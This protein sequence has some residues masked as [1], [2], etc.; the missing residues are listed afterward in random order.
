[1][2]NFLKKPI[3]R[4][5][6]NFLV[7]LMVFQGAPYW[8]IARNYEF[9]L[10]GRIFKLATAEAAPLGQN[11]VLK[12]VEYRWGGYSYDN[13]PI[14]EGWMHVRI[15]NPCPEDVF[16]VKATIS[17]W[18]E[19]CEIVD[20][21]VTVGNIPE[22]AS[23]WS[24][25]TF[26]IKVDMANP[27]DPREG[28][29]WTIEYDDTSGVHHIIKNVPEFPIT[30]DVVPTVSLTI[31]PAS[32][33]VDEVVNIRVTAQ[34]NVGLCSLILTVN[35]EEVPYD[36]EGNAT[37]LPTEEGEYTV[38]A[39]ATDADGNIAEDTETFV[40]GVVN[41]PPVAH[42]GPDQTVF[43]GDTV[44]LDGSLSND[45]DGDTLTFSWSFTSLP[46]GS[47][48]TLSDSTIVNPTFMADIAGAYV[49]Q[50]IVNDG[51]LN[52]D[53]DTVVINAYEL[54][55]ANRNPEITSTPPTTADIGEL[56][57]YD[58][59]AT[60]PDGDTLTFSLTKAP[61]G[62][63]INA[64]TGLISWT[65]TEG[66][67]YEVEVQV[68]DGKGGTDTQPFT[69]LVS[70]TANRPPQITSSPVTSATASISYQYDVEATDQ[71]GYPLTFSLTQAPTGMT[72]D[73]GTGL[74]EWTPDNAQIG[75]HDVTVRVEDALGAYDTQSFTITVSAVGDITAPQVNVTV[76]PLEVNPDE[77]VTITV[78]A[79]DDVGVVSIELSV[80]GTPL[81]LDIN[82]QATF[83]SSTPGLFTA[84]A[85]ARD[86]KGN[87]GTDSQDFRVL[88]PGDT[89]AP[90]VSI[91]SPATDSEL[92]SPTD[93]LGT[94]SDDNLVQ[95]TLEYS[96]KDKNTFVTF[97]TGTTSVVNGVLGTL[98]TTTLLNDL[99]DIRLTAEDANGQTSSTNV[100]YRIT[101]DLKVGNF[102]ITLQDLSIPV[103]G[104][105]IT[106]NRTYDSRDKASHDF[107][108]GW[109]IDIQTTKVKENRILGSGWAQLSTGGWLP[110][111]YLQPDGEHYVSITLPDG[112]VEE[113]NFT[114]TPSSQQLV[115]L[116]STTAAF[117]ARP[118][119]FST[120]VPLG[121][122]DLW[123]MGGVGA[124][125]LLDWDTL[126][127]YDP[128]EYQLTTVDG[129]VYIINQ[130]AGIKT[131]TDPNGNTLTFTAN[132]ITHSSGKGV[133]FT[134]DGEGRIT[135]ITDPSGNTITYKYDARG[136]LVSVTDQEG[137]K[138][139]YTYNST[140][141]LLDIKDPRGIRPARNIY[142]DEGRLI[143][144]IDAYGNRI[145][146]EHRVD[147]RQE[148][149][150]DRKGN[151]TVY[152]YD[153]DGNVLS[154]TDP[155]G[156]TT[157]YTYDAR[158]NKLTET[159]PLGNTTKYT[160]DARDN[161]LTQ[162]D[163]LG[164][165]TTY[166]YNARNQVLTTTDPNGN[167]TT[168]TYDANGNLL[169]TTD[170]LGNITTNTYD[171]SG[172][173]LSTTDCLGNVTTYEY[174]AYGNLIKQTDALGNVTTYTY[175][176]NG[177]Q[178]TQTT[179]R[180]TDAGPV[181]MTIT[182]EYDG[183]NRLIKTTDPDGNVTIT[184]YNA[185]GKK[186]ATVDKNGNRTTYEYD[187]MGN[188]IKTTYPDGTTE[189][190]TYDA[191]GNKLTSTDRAGRTTQYE[192]DP[193]NRL[194]QT[195]FP[196]GR[197]TSTE[198]DAA[199]RVIATIDENGNRTS[200][201]YDAAGR[202]TK[203]IDALGNVTTYTYDANG[204]QTSVTDANGNTTRYEYDA[205]NRRIKTIFSDGTFT[206]VGY[207][208]LGRKIS[209]TDQAG[210]TTQ[211]E[212][213]ALGRLTKVIDA[214]G[215]K[216]T[217][218]Y[219]EVGNK[220]SQTDPNG[221]TT[222]WAYDNLGRIVK[223]TL[224]LGMSETFTY[225][226]NGNILTK[227]DFNGNTITYTYDVNNRLT[228]KS[229]P[230]GSQV[231]FTY[232]ATGQRETVTD[233][234]GVTLYSYDLRDRIIEVINPDGTAITYTYD[235][236][237]NR[238][239]VTVPSGTT[240]YTYDKL[241]RLQTVTDPDGGVTTYTYDS[242]GNRASVTYP[243]GTV[244]EYTYDTLN[245]LTYLENRK[246]TGEII[247]SYTYTLGPAGNR[248]RVVED[249]GRAVNY[250]YDNLYRLTEEDITDPVLGDETISY[251]YDAF[252][253]RLTKTD[254]TG[255]TNY[256]YDENDRLLTEEAPTY[257][258]TYTYDDN[259]NT[260]S[261]SDG[262]TVTN[263][264]YD[265]ENRLIATQ[266]GASQ[267][268]Y[269]YDADGIRVRS[270]AN[271]TVT[272][273][274]VDKNRDYAQVLEE[275]DDIGSLIVSYIHGDDLISQNRG[276]SVSYYHYDGQMSTRKL[277][278]AV[279][280][281]TDT[282]VYDAFG[283]LLNRTGTT[284]NNYLYTGEQYDP[285]IGFY[286][287]RARYYAASIGRFLN[288]DPLEGNIYDPRALHKYLYATNNPI[289]LSDPSGQQ[290]SLVSVT[291][292]CAIIGALTAA[293][294]YTYYHPPGSERFTW[295]GFIIWT[296]SGAA[297]GAVVGYLGWYAWLYWGPAVTTTI[298][299]TTYRIGRHLVNRWPHINVL[300]S[301]FIKHGHQIANI[302]RETNYTIQRYAADAAFVKDYYVYKTYNVARGA[303]YYIKYLGVS[304]SGKSYFAFVVE[305]GGKIVSFRP[306]WVK[307]AAKF[308]PELF[309]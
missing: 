211:F 260:I 90:T 209:E 307:D 133:T 116:S 91:T 234:R 33:N 145:D 121:S 295:K 197:S 101:E 77:A 158:G 7:F 222:R 196:D 54:A 22:G 208:C 120:L 48:A 308:F 206:T 261:K 79:T 236:R 13:W 250:T 159:D 277:T 186:S 2:N 229:Y 228:R 188:L 293:A 193:L 149:V 14:F 85:T 294:L 302:L 132:G 136:D 62:M 47:T 127:P 4:L 216:T 289:N 255:V 6:V 283:I 129:T 104:I 263:Y 275:R 32:V 67:N 128:N 240:T 58:V 107:G 41:H 192:Y 207:D 169:T 83:S 61:N 298:G 131:V 81:S 256:T 123:I 177:N 276:G 49:V 18:P 105:P 29:V 53:P 171:A 292:T 281:I 166:T 99:Y 303:W 72:I 181:T 139:T 42:A 11:T 232:T 242:V 52:S 164:N 152:E 10:H 280:M 305:K 291:I 162:T 50:L 124:V 64:S 146:Y 28:V 36:T 35:G 200:Y 111:Y 25:D 39:V 246:S 46:E 235:P 244:T 170:P 220:I 249:S 71:D 110:T 258:N 306:L 19:N 270:T 202:R 265:Y 94:A 135:Q 73:I 154:Q 245:R 17:D 203:V 86:A 24:Q 9:V 266:T 238:T 194:I 226:A 172:N 248:I 251:T 267:T 134:R 219:D 157:T 187:L 237:G 78:D 97:A 80:N 165:T 66:G 84:T 182:N 201:E 12:C 31:E 102:T 212:Y 137:N 82:N 114:P 45:P 57:T 117:T 70:A 8:E 93:I 113:F 125:E 96:P 205:L 155:L 38:L 103:A 221:H 224:P 40:A 286:Y 173:L 254:S 138:T 278:D 65:P 189:T 43:V 215:N 282:Y 252:G 75:Q 151:I 247:S 204:N 285:N 287:L 30:D 142:D 279:E 88:A 122:T 144:H 274:L 141:G 218:T 184:E 304:Q 253:N 163:P 297:A 161:L 296:I 100:V 176:A 118:G 143:A 76:D 230:D 269:D 87:A 1:M 179:T 272:N 15:E 257:S 268:A 264:T 95:Y 288:I 106:I 290:F 20:G 284:V 233:T 147:A 59:E 243:N 148:V 239:S 227:T 191:N 214:L 89:T 69:I 51:S 34:D 168:N 198:Y 309:R 5:L 178:L 190:A 259:G 273:Y 213:D 231:S 74:I 262:T 130:T 98:D 180:T 68:S 108:Y 175:D 37:Y 140:H 199:G 301:H 112:R 63:E 16:N 300:R 185:I 126:M 3:S 109:S 60:D 223:H 55:P 21:E 167:T 56:Y 156:N 150:T 115:P 299:G 92:T 119:T 225:D 271:G 195:I 27:V 210:I 174:D 241:N 26:Q 44:Q 23:A 160:Y 217:Y 183:L 153:D